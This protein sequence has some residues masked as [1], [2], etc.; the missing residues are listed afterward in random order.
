MCS[1]SLRAYRV[2]DD[3]AALEDVRRR[4]G[5]HDPYVL[6]VGTLEPRKNLERL[7]EAFSRARQA[8]RRE[9]LV[10]AGQ[11][12][13]KYRGLLGRIERSGLASAVRLLGYVPDED[14]PAIYNLASVVAFPSLYE[15]FGLPILEGM[16]CGVPV[17]TSDRASMVELAGDA[18]LLVDP[19]DVTALEGGL[20]RLLD[21][22]ELRRELARRGR[23]RAARF[24]WA[25]A[26][27]ETVRLYE[28]VRRPV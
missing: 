18:A 1:W 3:A 15:G 11:L 24:S 23:G 6:F 19:T 28:R 2:I 17:L 9:K 26:A 8:G 16:A 14:L 10:L 4:Y 5:L 25:R 7:L 13:W 20:V 27:A 21:D 22:P 12:G